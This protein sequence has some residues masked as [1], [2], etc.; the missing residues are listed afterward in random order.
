MSTTITINGP[1]DIT[2]NPAHTT[3]LTPNA[4]VYY[5]PYG[6]GSQDR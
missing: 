6:F 4:D 5:G 3:P 2:V 1:V